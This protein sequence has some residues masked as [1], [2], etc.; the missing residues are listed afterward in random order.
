MIM[1]LLR[2]VLPPQITLSKH[3]GS[4]NGHFNQVFPADQWFSSTYEPCEEMTFVKNLL[5]FSENDTTAYRTLLRHP[6]INVFTDIKWKSLECLYILFLALQILV[7]VAYSAFICATIFIDCP[8]DIYVKLQQGLHKINQ[9]VFPNGTIFN[10]TEI[11]NPDLLC[12]IN[13]IS[14]LLSM[15]VTVCTLIILL[16]EMQHAIYDLKEYLKDVFNYFQLIGFMSVIYTVII[17]WNPNSPLYQFLYPVA[18]VRN[19]SL[20]LRIN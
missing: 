3:L 13:V 4:S 16:K 18:A 6:L 2:T 9:H 11:I 19:I 1:I 15:F 5:D 20:E 17:A 12:E 14:K 8:Y 10:A 7:L